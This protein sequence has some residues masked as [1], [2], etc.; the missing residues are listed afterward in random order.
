MYAARVPRLAAFL[1]VASMLGCGGQLTA[2]PSRGGPEWH[3]L[4]SEHFVLRTDLRY[5][6]AVR[7][8]QMLELL[9]DAYAAAGWRA[10]GP[11]E[12]TPL[13]VFR[14]PPDI[15]HFAPNVDGHYIPHPLLPTLAVAAWH[16]TEQ[17]LETIKHEL[18]HVIAYR[19]MPRQPLWFDEG[20]ATFYQTAR[21]DRRGR[22]M[23][24]G[25]PNMLWYGAMPAAELLSDRVDTH[26]RRFYT[27]AWL[28]VHYLSVRRSGDFAAYQ[29][30]LASG[31]SP[32]DAWAAHFPDLD[33]TTL[34]EAL[35]KHLEGGA[36][37][38]YSWEV[39]RKEIDVEVR[40]LEDADVC[41]LR[42]RLYFYFRPGGDWERRA[43]ENLE[44]ALRARPK[45]L[46]A[47]L[48]ELAYAARS[49]EEQLTLARELTVMHPDAWT[50]WLVLATIEDT[51]GA[52]DSGALERVL[53][54]K[55]GQPRASMLAAR[56]AMREG[57]TE[58]ALALSTSAVRASPTDT[59]ILHTHAALLD[60]S[61]D[62]HGACDLLARSASARDDEAER[63]RFEAAFAA[64]CQ[65]DLR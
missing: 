56:R 1:V 7:T 21:F 48:V 13:V 30:A 65:G 46:E 34:D 62:R 35:S 60:E 36:M 42:A 23:V 54:L 3:E 57:R 44:L 52:Q 11:V 33:P 19:R 5:E 43:R 27:N 25:A 32:A 8:L 14:A 18:T 20:I 47:R 45:H 4:E 59:V 10:T 51:A 37:R 2:L 38:G 64:R 26:D 17:G 61:G 53:A 28:L 12:R 31:Q 16:P 24:G 29:G 22:F 58:D 41:A 15:R 6:R 49:A 63:E 40:R 9:L 39:E 55:P 50:A